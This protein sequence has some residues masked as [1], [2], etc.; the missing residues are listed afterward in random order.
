MIE[1]YRVLLFRYLFKK[2]KLNVA[3]EYL[4]NK[5]LQ[6]IENEELM[7]KEQKS[8]CKYSK[9]FYLL[10]KININFLTRKE[11]DFLNNVDENAI[12]DN[13]VITFLEN[14]Y[15]KLLF[16]DSSGLNIYYGPHSSNY[17][18]NDKDIVIG[19]KYDEFGFATKKL[20]KIK[21]IEE[22]KEILKDVQKCLVN[23][24]Q[25]NVRIIVYNELYEKLFH[26]K[27]G[28]IQTIFKYDKKG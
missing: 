16:W 15:H 24:S 25:L 14:T 1:K 26:S 13:D 8:C 21:D 10:N 12:I 9:Y 4:K 20:K 17:A 11:R 22:N 3:E 2:I 23:L 27:L 5:N 28:D 7:C 18:V 6:Y 19:L